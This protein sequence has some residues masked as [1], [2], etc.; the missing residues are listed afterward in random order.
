[1]LYDALDDTTHGIC[2]PKIFCPG[3]WMLQESRNFSTFMFFFFFEPSMCVIPKERLVT[4]LL[5][6][7]LNKGSR[8]LDQARMCKQP[9]TIKTKGEINSMITFHEFIKT[10]PF[11]PHISINKWHRSSRLKVSICSWEKP[12]Y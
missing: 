3:K 10:L 6:S 9:L 7:N 8:A 1:M 11:S 4:A 5:T 12:V 2:H